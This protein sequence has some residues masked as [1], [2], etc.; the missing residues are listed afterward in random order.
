VSL[1]VPT[2][3]YDIVYV[4]VLFLG[5]LTNV[6]T[7]PFASSFCPRS[8]MVG[9]SENNA[10]AT[11]PKGD[12]TTV[13]VHFND[14]LK[15]CVQ[16]RP[17]DEMLKMVFQKSTGR[18]LGVHIFGADAAEMIHHASSLVNN[19]IENTIWHVVKSV[20]PAVTYAEVLMKACQRA[21]DIILGTRSPIRSN[22]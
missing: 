4:F 14:T 10:S 17:E 6:I 2:F 1:F 3:P 12:W 7:V 8:G 13:T 15:S 19:P 22:P 18:I 16:P 21:V 5:Q 11:I 9:L 20:P